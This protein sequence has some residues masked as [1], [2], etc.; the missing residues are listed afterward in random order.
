MLQKPYLIEFSRIGNDDR[1]FIS[2]CEKGNLPFQTKRIYWTYNVP[3]DFI[4]GGH[5]H[6]RLEQILLALSGKINLRIELINGELYEFMLDRPDIG[7]YIPKMSWR[8]M[9]YYGNS[10][11]LCIANME[12]Q[13]LDY[14]RS[15]DDFKKLALK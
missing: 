1:G 15:Y 14:I 13:E 12:F 9:K 8:T 2:V 6:I 11:Q 5:A 4:R 10:I 7:V 3:N